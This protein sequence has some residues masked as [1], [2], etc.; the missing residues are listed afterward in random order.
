MI[1]DAELELSDKQSIL[2]TGASTDF[3]DL[4][5]QR[6]PGVGQPVYPYARVTEAYNNLTSLKV[7]VQ[8]GNAV[9]G[10]GA[11]TFA[12]AVDLTSN[13]VLLAA[14]GLNKTVPLPPVPQGFGKFRFLRFYFTVTGVAPTTGKVTAGFTPHSK[15]ANEAVTY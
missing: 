1:L 11:P 5:A 6:D 7:A 9:D 3:L 13:T 14:L 10:A 8:G 12:D 2:A 15:T 4:V